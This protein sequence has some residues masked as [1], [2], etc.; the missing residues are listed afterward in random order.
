MADGW[1]ARSVWV[2]GA[3]CAGG[4]SCAEFA[5]GVG[6]WGDS[7]C[8]AFV[9]RGFWSS[10]GGGE[11]DGDRAG[12]QTAW[13]VIALVGGSGGARR[14]ALGDARAIALEWQAFHAA[15]DRP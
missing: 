11:G 1:A 8:T 3:G 15:L 5:G 12:G 6:G 9:G 10:Y 4:R 2:V 7:A 14:Q 13:A